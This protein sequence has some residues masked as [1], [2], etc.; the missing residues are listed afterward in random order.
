MRD[1]QDEDVI[2]DNVGNVYTKILDTNGKI[3]NVIPPNPATENV[4]PVKDI[5]S[6]YNT[7]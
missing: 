1:I 5:P 2:Q 7:I 4:I 3:L 6:T